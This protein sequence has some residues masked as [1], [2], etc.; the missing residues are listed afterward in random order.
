MRVKAC[1]DPSL[2]DGTAND[3]NRLI[4]I[5]EE[6]SFQIKRN[7][8]VDKK[9]EEQ[10]MKEFCKT[11]FPNLATN[12]P[13]QGWLDGR[14]LLA[15][16]NKEIDTANDIIETWVPGTPTRLSSADTL[17]DYQDVMRFN[18]ECLISLCL[19]GFPRLII[20]FKPG[21]PL[22]ILHNISPKEGLCNWAK[23]FYQRTL[24]NRLLVCK[25][26]RTDKDVIIPWIKFIPDPGSWERCQFPVCMAFA[27]TVNKSQ[28]KTL[29]QV[30][31]GRQMI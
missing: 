12:L 16:T 8:D 17:E 23:L 26:A 5:P 9:A 28:G 3:A 21:M 1:G 14:V 18:T 22:M 6:M 25:L 15:L 2:S 19:N 4:T 7:T 10:S 31:G 13:S 29:K 30:L 20:I 24:N 27:T 11:V